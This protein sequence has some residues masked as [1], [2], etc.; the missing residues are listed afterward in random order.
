LEHA[1]AA[2]VVVCAYTIHGEDGGGG[3]QL[4][5]QLQAMH[6]GF[7]AGSGGQRKLERTASRIEVRS[8]MLGD[9]SSD[10]ASQE[11]ANNQAP[12]IT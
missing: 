1:L 3:R 2:H 8:E 10:K 7:G 9:G 4:R 5:G 12:D 11:I 6:K